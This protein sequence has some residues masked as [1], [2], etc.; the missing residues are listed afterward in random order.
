MD[1]GTDVNSGP[2][3]HDWAPP[4]TGQQVRLNHHTHGTVTGVL[5]TR[6]DDGAVIWVHLNDGGGRRLIHRDDGY[7]L[8]RN[9]GS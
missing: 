9:P 8:A 5:D 2:T 4:Q 6:T 1:L 7:R 3:K